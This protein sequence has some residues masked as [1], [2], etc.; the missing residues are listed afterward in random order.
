MKIFC[1]MVV[2]GLLITGPSFN[3]FASV[4][5][6]M[7]LTSGHS[8]YFINAGVHNKMPVSPAKPMP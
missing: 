3:A 4:V 8:T 1:L 6:D 5:Q 7:G 2:L